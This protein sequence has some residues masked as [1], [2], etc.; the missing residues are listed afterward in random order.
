MEPFSA[1]QRDAAFPS[2]AFLAVYVLPQIEL[3]EYVL[4]KARFTACPCTTKIVNPK[5]KINE[6]ANRFILFILS[7]IIV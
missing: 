3:A 2:K 1:D 5:R 7:S 6:I 4:F